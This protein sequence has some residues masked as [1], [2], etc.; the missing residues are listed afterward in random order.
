MGR[1]FVSLLFIVVLAGGA[2]WF[3]TN[4]DDFDNDLDNDVGIDIDN[5]VEVAEDHE[6][7]VRR[8][9]EAIEDAQENAERANVL[10]G[11]LEDAVS[12]ARESASQINALTTDNRAASTSYEAALAAAADAEDAAFVMR[13]YADE[14]SARLRDS[15]VIAQQARGIA[16][17]VESVERTKAEAERAAL[18]AQQA[19]IELQKQERALDDVNTGLT[20]DSGNTAPQRTQRPT[21]YD[22]AVT[23]RQP[24]PSEYRA[25]PR[26]EPETVV[27]IESNASDA[28]SARDAVR[29][30]R[31]RDTAPIIVEPISMETSETST[32]VDEDIS[33]LNVVVDPA[34]ADDTIIIRDDEPDIHIRRND[35]SAV[36]TEPN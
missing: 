22:R 19:E 7:R 30:R 32:I 16:E 17:V 29:A 10:A 20:Y 26:G 15:G 9:A 21:T 3:I 31:A 18:Q 8:L 2:W 33:D 24:Q 6:D 27:I 23:P 28:E 1:F 25:A 4:S 35:H 36:R 5:D 11:E 12:R 34:H 13:Q 14:M